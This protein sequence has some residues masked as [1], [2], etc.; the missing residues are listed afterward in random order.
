MVGQLQL[1]LAWCLILYNSCSL[2]TNL[3]IEFC[4][5][6]HITKQ[7]NQGTAYAY[8]VSTPLKNIVWKEYVEYRHFTQLVR[9]PK[10]SFFSN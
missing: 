7:L 6:N 3:L 8:H 4:P 5:L 1:L 9:H 2:F 10:P